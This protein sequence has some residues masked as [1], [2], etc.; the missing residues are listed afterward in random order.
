MWVNRALAAQIRANMNSLPAKTPVIRVAQFE[1]E[2]QLLR[3]LCDEAASRERR[4]ELLQ[5]QQRHPFLD[6]EHQVVFES[7]SFL[8]SCG[9]L[10]VDRLAVHLNNRGFPDVDLGKYFSGAPAKDALKQNTD[11]KTT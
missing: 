5:L 8:V 11:R 6:H 1:E 2:L 3:A 7:I 4:F 10:S 9:G